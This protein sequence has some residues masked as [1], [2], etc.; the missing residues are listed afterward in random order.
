MTGDQ[1]AAG[2]LELRGNIPIVLC[3][4]FSERFNE[5]QSRE[6]GIQRYMYKPVPADKLAKVV[7][8]VLDESVTA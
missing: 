8:E 2:I 4:G 7:R 6:L 1:L 5:T 3:T